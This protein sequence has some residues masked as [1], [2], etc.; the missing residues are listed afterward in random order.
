[1]LSHEVFSGLNGA[2]KIASFAVDRTRRQLGK[3][4]F[5]VIFSPQI[6][7]VGLA[8][9]HINHFYELCSLQLHKP[10]GLSNDAMHICKVLCHFSTPEIHSLYSLFMCQKMSPFKSNTT[11]QRLAMC[12]A[13]YES[14][15]HYEICVRVSHELKAMLGVKLS[16]NYKV[17]Q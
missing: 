8:F 16:C 4:H 17:H 14:Q 12:K 7:V 1:M 10:G 5:E 2:A 3:N 6:V 13:F 9:D 11:E 15:A